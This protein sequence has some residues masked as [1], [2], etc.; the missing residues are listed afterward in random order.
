MGNTMTHDF[1]FWDDYKFYFL[2]GQ[3]NS[4]QQ[5]SGPD[6]EAVYKKTKKDPTFVTYEIE[7]FVYK[8]NSLGFRSAEFDN[9]DKVKI[10]HAGCSL[11]EGVGLPLDHTWSG[12]VNHK[13]SEELQ[14]PITMYNIGVGGFS[15]DAIIRFVY[16]TLNSGRFNPDVVFL[17][18]PSPMRMEYLYTDSYNHSQMLHFVPHFDFSVDPVAKELS[19]NIS[20]LISFRHRAH[21]MFK[22]LLFLKMFLDNKGIPFFFSTWDNFK[23]TDF[24]PTYSKT[25]VDFFTFLKQELPKSLQ[26]HF[27]PAYMQFDN[28]CGLN[29]KFERKFKY[30]I[31]RDGM[32]YGPNSHFNFANHFYQQIKDTYE[33]G[34]LMDDWKK[35]TNK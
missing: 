27:I 9:T 8:R 29:D 4:T 2:E 20:T 10:L 5:W 18:L 12:F 24:E 22:S 28:C 7:D 21:E 3:K 35:A 26:E 31:A 16:I 34:V 11:T 6:C 23:V 1:N 17:L 32:H 25:P 13:I 15:I 30:N 19:K 14:R 33:F